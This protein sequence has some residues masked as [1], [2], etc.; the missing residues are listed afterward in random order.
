MNKEK[1]GQEPAFPLTEYKYTGD[2]VHEWVSE[3]GMSKRLH[4]ASEILKSIASMHSPKSLIPAEVKQAYDYA[5]ELL[6][7]EYI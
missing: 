2:G 1:L 7:Q 6:R 3:Y 5:D 4:I